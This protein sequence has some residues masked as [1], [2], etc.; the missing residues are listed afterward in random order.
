MSQTK[1]YADVKLSILPFIEHFN[2]HIELLSLSVSSVIAT[3]NALDW[4]IVFNCLCSSPDILTPIVFMLCCCMLKFSLSFTRLNR[5]RLQHNTNISLLLYLVL[6]YYY[7]SQYCG[8][9]ISRPFAKTFPAFSMV[10]FCVHTKG[11]Q[12]CFH[13]Y[14]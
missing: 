3:Q 12:I 9:Y 11:L 6:Y 4:N 13:F 10:F 7:I 14:S 1:V 8:R 2:I 5:A